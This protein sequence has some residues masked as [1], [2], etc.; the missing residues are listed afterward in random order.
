VTVAD[1]VVQIDILRRGEHKTMAC[2]S[3]KRR[4]VAMIE[5]DSL[6]LPTAWL[7]RNAG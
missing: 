3:A 1:D 7:A 2:P 4:A 5:E 6:G